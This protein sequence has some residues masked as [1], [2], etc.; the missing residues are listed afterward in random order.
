M[1]R[2]IVSHADDFVTAAASVRTAEP[3][4]AGVFSKLFCGM[5]GPVNC[6]ASPWL[7]RDMSGA[8]ASVQTANCW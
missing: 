8:P 4:R 1:P 7:M 6:A 2:A 5:S 3:L